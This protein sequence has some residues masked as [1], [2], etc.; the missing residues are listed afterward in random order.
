VV[1]AAVPGTLVLPAGADLIGRY[2]RRGEELGFVLGSSPLAVRVPVAQADIDHVRSRTESI[3]IRLAST[4][5]LVHT[6]RLV[7]HA[8]AASHTL[9][10]EILTIDA[11]GRIARDPRDTSPLQSVEPYFLFELEVPGLAVE[12]VGERAQVLF[13]HRAEALAQRWY[14]GARRLLLRQFNV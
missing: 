5:R 12:R 11:G 13:R 1:R 3:E 14:R 8:P 4:P 10:H 9:P 7:A 6:A 2:V